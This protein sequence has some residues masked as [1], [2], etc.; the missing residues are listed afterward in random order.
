MTFYN[1]LTKEEAMAI[2]GGSN[3]SLAYD[4]TYVIVSAVKWVVDLF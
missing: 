2:N 3:D 4:I 1:E